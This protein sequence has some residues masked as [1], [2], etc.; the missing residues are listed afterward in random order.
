MRQ[1]QRAL[2]LVQPHSEVEHRWRLMLQ[3]QALLRLLVTP[4]HQAQVRE[5]QIWERHLQ[6]KH[7]PPLAPA[8]ML[9]QDAD[10]QPPAD[11]LDA[12]LTQQGGQE[13]RPQWQG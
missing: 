13:R 3:G 5:W 6:S 12:N 1:M 9:S 4:Q 2:V 8:C 10:L 7:A 11:A